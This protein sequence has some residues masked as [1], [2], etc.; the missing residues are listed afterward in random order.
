MGDDGFEHVTYSDNLSGSVGLIDLAEPL[1]RMADILAQLNRSAHFKDHPGLHEF[2]EA[3][4]GLSHL[5]RIMIQ[6]H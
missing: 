1:V 3:L 4:N 5:Y 2:G 6:P